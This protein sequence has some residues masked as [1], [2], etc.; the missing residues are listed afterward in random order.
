MVLLMSKPALDPSPRHYPPAVSFIRR[1]ARGAASCPA[2][3]SFTDIEAWLLKEALAE[4]DL[5]LLFDSF[6]W[7]LVAAGSG[8]ERASLHVGTL[9]PQ[10]FGFA[11]NWSRAD[12]LCDEVK[13]APAALQA[14][15]YKRNPLFRVIEHGERFRGDTRDAATRARYPLLAELATSGITEYLAEVLTTGSAYHNAVTLATKDPAGFS[16]EQRTAIETALKLLG[17]HVERHIVLR[18]AHNVLNTYLGS[19]AGDAV[20]AGSIKRG[21]GRP[22]RSIIWSS[23]LRGFTELSE[24]LAGNEVTVLLDAYFE[25]LVTA[26]ADHGGEIL[27]FIGDGL[28]AVFS[29]S[30]ETAARQAAASALAA[31]QDALVALDRLNAAPPPHLAAID[32]WRP[33]KTGIALHSGEVFFGNIGSPDRLDFT[34]IG[35]AVNEASRVESL[36]K[37]LGRSLLITEAVAILL[38]RP[39]EDLG[40]HLLRGR[41]E[42]ISV[43]SPS[44]P[45]S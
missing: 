24:R 27:K 2:T 16:P 22:I 20:L 18:I 9:H 45:H 19:A 3:V 44:T 8:L 30:D 43:F 40:Q 29:F 33:L 35:K 23:D 7:R 36:T 41:V 28:L 42:P 1:S 25:C 39:L 10:L 17:L 5:L 38:D 14:D 34:V 13:V 4:T 12:G 31:A 11:W 6:A 15:A 37:V 21:S 26:I 32:G